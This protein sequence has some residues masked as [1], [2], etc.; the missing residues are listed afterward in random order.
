MK[1]VRSV[2]F[3][4]LGLGCASAAEAATCGA[5]PFVFS[6]NTVAD[7]T[8]VN[9]NFN[10]LL[11]CA[12]SNLAP[13]ASPT[14]SGTV[15]TPNLTVTTSAAFATTAT[16]TDNQ[17]GVVSA[18]HFTFEAL[19]QPGLTANTV[20]TDGGF[21]TPNW[22]GIRSVMKVTAGSTQLVASPF[23]G[24]YENFVGSL[25]HVASAFGGYGV[26]Q[27][28]SSACWGFNMALADAGHSVQLFNELDINSSNTGTLV[29]GLQLTGASSAQFGGSAVLVNTPGTGIGWNAGAFVSAASATSLIGLHL[30]GV[31]G[32]PAGA[33]NAQEILFT[34]YTAPNTAINAQI[35]LTSGNAYI[36]NA[37]AGGLEAFEIGGTAVFEAITATPGV[38]A[39]GVGVIYNNGSSTS[40]QQI[41][42]GNANS[43]G[44]ARCLT[45]QN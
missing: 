13:L 40:L 12:N 37:P 16:I 42:I 35:L 5:L 17:T 31:I 34:A 24:Y 45:V 8:Q 19:S 41:A 21:G 14:F 33:G 20:L 38:G 3:G 6:N 27:V 44:S 39:T 15:T 25:T 23:S 9:A 36:F 7:A 10:A 11:S 18:D 22:D 28:N 1:I 43:C 32:T 26:C 30:D 29:N 4:L 2:L